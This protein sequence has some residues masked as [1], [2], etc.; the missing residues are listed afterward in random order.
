[1][2]LW[3]PGFVCLRWFGSECSEGL[4]RAVG[5]YGSRTAGASFRGASSHV[6]QWALALC[7][8][9]LDEST[10]LQYGRNVSLRREYPPL[11]HAKKRTSL[12]GLGRRLPVAS[13][14]QWRVF[15]SQAGN[16]APADIQTPKNDASQSLAA[17]DQTTYNSRLKICPAATTADPPCHTAKDGW[18]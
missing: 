1:M 18:H 4:P 12:C 15:P 9:S 13:R 16:E 10:G 3:R 8:L 11:E 7:C 5:D 17:P 6:A 14:F 2:F